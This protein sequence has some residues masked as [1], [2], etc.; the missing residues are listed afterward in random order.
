M[1]Q[2]AVD[3]IRAEDFK[4]AGEL[5]AEGAA[6]GRTQRLRL[7]PA[8]HRPRA[9]RRLRLAVQATR[10]RCSCSPDQA[11]IANDLG[12]LAFRLGMTPQA[13]KLFRHFLE[14]LPG[15]SRRRQQPGLRDPRP[16]P[17]DGG[18]RGPAPGDHEAARTTPCCGTPWARSL[19]ETGRLHQRPDLLRARRFAST[20]PSPRP[21][22]TA[23][24]PAWRWATSP[25]RSSDCEAAI[26]RVRAEDERQMMRLARST[27]L[28][29][30]G[31]DRRG[32]GRLRGAAGPAVHRRH[33]LPVDAPRWTPGDDLAGKS[34]LVIG[35]AGP[36]RRD[37]VRQHP[38]RRDRA[39]WARRAA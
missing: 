3:A 32:L 8:G 24:T 9:R 37:A 25:A 39:R 19:A 35:R 28:M 13:E 4:T 27:I 34:L 6:A 16:G 21:A 23:A 2:R 22:T 29:A 31:R 33:P 38:A 7:V 11:E 14:P 20:R 17:L 10:R 1:L 5:G 18:D 12:R 36:G 26:A 30:L 15:P